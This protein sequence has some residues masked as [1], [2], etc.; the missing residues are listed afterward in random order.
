MVG[1]D[2]AIQGTAPVYAASVADDPGSSQTGCI[3]TAAATAS[4]RLIA[5]HGIAPNGGGTFVNEY[6]ILADVFSP[7][8][9]RSQWRR[10]S[11]PTRPMPTTA[12][13]SSAIPMTCGVGALGYSRAPSTTRNGRGW[14]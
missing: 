1:S 4:N 13:I 10:S 5:T 11:K 12:T 14:S 6:T 7:V 8:A 9:S 2:L 3:T